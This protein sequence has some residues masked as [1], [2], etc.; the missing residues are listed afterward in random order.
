MTLEYLT[1]HMTPVA[2]T[3]GTLF[4]RCPGAFHPGPNMM[5]CPWVIFRKTCVDTSVFYVPFTFLQL[6]K[7]EKH[8]HQIHSMIT[9]TRRPWKDV[10][11]D[12]SY[13]KQDFLGRVCWVIPPKRF[14]S[15]HHRPCCA[16]VRLVE[17]EAH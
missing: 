14:H 3:D 6:D 12:L 9:P 10:D 13:W 16:S 8:R 7:L 15:L 17:T 11:D 2:G 4:Q 5:L 1:S